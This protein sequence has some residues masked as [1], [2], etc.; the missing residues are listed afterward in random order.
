[1]SDE[2]HERK[3]LT[4][5]PKILQLAEE[6]MALRHFNDLAP[7]LSQLIRE[8]HERRHGPAVLHDAPSPPPPPPSSFSY[9]KAKKRK[10]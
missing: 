6:L 2:P 3:N 1:M 8:E 10:R 4:F 9:Y 7:F 5:H